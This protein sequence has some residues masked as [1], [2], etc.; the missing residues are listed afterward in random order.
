MDILN[1]KGVKFIIINLLLLSLLNSC[2][3]TQEKEKQSIQAIETK[4]EPKPKKTN[5]NQKKAIKQSYFK[6]K[7]EELQ[8][9]Q[10]PNKS[11]QD[12]ESPVTQG[13]AKK[14]FPSEMLL[15]TQ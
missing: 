15:N 9:G 5:L 7:L 1:Y 6:P 11:F 8:I 12:I 4:E 2:E 3:F 14:P 13:R 10:D